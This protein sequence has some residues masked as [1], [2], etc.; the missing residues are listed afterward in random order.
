MTP[1][2]TSYIVQDFLAVLE[3]TELP[4]VIMQNKKVYIGISAFDKMHELT[5]IIGPTKGGNTLQN[6]SQ[7]QC[8]RMILNAM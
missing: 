7:E 3:I 6:L 4:A 8:T 1:D 2:L 5:D